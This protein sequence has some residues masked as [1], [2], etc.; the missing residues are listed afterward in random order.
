MI[1]VGILIALQINNWNEKNNRKK[2]ETQ[3]LT[4]MRNALVDDLENFKSGYQKVQDVERRIISL[5]KILNSKQAVDTIDVLCGAVYGILRFNLNTAAYEEL[6]STGFNL[7][8]NPSIRRLIIKIYDTHLKF[9]DHANNIEDNVVLEALRPY[10][11]QNFSKIRF[12]ISSTPN[13]LQFILTDPF[14]HNL[15]DYR[16]T[17]LRS[18]ALTQYP[19][20]IAEMAQLIDQI[21][22]FI[23][24]Q[25]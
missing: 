6:K 12:L 1:V 19:Q 25:K 5:Q 18:L 2:E 8:S 16:L 15:V 3:I 23:R 22:G 4:E 7:I 24:D 14:Y 10:Y 21:D 13:D 11:L 9:I 20:V 17:S